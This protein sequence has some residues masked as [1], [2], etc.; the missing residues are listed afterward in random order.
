VH[1][2]GVHDIEIELAVA[3]PV[4]LWGPLTVTLPSLFKVPV[5]PSNG[6]ANE[7]EQSVCVTITRCPTREGSQCAVMAHVPATLGQVAL[8]SPALGDDE[9][10]LHATSDESTT[11]ERVRG[12]LPSYAPGT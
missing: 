5:K 12:I 3:V 2:P 11:T 8:L 10:E 4:Q 7:S 6:A 1:V 9:L